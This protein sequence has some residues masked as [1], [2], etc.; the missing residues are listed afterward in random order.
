MPAK[1]V[2]AAGFK[3]ET[4]TVRVTSASDPVGFDWKLKEERAGF[5]TFRAERP[6][7]FTDR[8]STVIHKGLGLQQ[9]YAF[10]ADVAFATQAVELAAP[11]G[12][13]MTASNAL[14]RH[15]TDVVAIASIFRARIA[16][17]DK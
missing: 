13:S 15:E 7:R 4:I 1:V 14:N 9:K 10:A 11:R 6:I 12:K 8:A 2:P 16:E 17:A 3:L 5:S